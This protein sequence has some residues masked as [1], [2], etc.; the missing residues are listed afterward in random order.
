MGNPGFWNKYRC[1]ERVCELASFGLYKSTPLTVENSAGVTPLQMLV[2]KK[3]GKKLRMLR[4]LLKYKDKLAYGDKGQ[5]LLLGFRKNKVETL[6]MF[7]N[8]GIVN[9]ASLLN[10]MEQKDSEL[11]D[12]KLSELLKDRLVKFVKDGRLN[13]DLRDESTGNSLLHELADRHGKAPL[14]NWYE[15][16]KTLFEQNT[17]SKEAIEKNFANKTVLQLSAEWR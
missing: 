6:Q 13:A 16:A 15:I 12:F 3:G 7:S 9:W 11:F 2:G 10:H 17:F 5:A 1:K 4:M 14:E 8:A